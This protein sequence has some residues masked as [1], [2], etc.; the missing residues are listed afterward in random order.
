MSFASL[1]DISTPIRGGADVTLG[2]ALPAGTRALWIG[3]GGDVSVT[4]VLGGT[5]VFVN[6]PDGYLLPVHAAQVNVGTTATDIRALF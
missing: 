1:N 4:F 5:T 3:T 2:A 6:V